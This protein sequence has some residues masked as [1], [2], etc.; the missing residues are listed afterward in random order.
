MPEETEIHRNVR[1]AKAGELAETVLEVPS[2]VVVMGKKQILPGYCLLLRDPVVPDLNVLKP[3]ERA[4]FF[5]DLGILGDAILAVTGAA[6]INYEIL[7]NKEPALH[8]HAFPR[9]AD[10]PEMYRTKPIWLYDWETAPDYLPQDHDPL[11][12]RIAEE[13]KQRLGS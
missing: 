9:Y 5:H 1:A 8:A 11:K 7:G 2:G 6:R 10:E 12:Q 3:E 4:Q 13:L